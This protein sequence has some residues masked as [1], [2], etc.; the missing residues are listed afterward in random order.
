[1]LLISSGAVLL[2]AMIFL[3][4]FGG[5]TSTDSLPIAAN[6]AL[7]P[8]RAIRDFSLTN[9][10]GLAFVRTNLTGRPWAVNLIFTRCPGPCTQL[11]GVMRSVQAGLPKGSEARLLS[12]TSDPEFDTPTVLSRYADKVGADQA[13]WQF[14]TGTR[15]AIQRLATEDLMLVLRENS[16][17]QRATPDDLFLHS[18]LIILVDRKGQVRNAVEGLELG[19]AGR[20]LEI[21]AELERER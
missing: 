3:T 13:G 8:I 11:S 9:H 2:A 17:A 4:L 14:V 15:A 1:M 6:R 7:P 21:L 18:T 16:E 5:S 20:V 10:S 12:L 19:A